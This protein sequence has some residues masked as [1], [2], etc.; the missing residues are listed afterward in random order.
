MLA[1]ITARSKVDVGAETGMGTPFPAALGAP[2]LPS[3]S[4]ATCKR[5]K[6][7]ARAPSVQIGLFSIAFASSAFAKPTTHCG[8]RRYMRET[9][10]LTLQLKFI[11]LPKN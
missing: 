1:R 5:Q 8:F 2:S 7:A 4:A 6:V 3:C 9:S 10:V 11:Y